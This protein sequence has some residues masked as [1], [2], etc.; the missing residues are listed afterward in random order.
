M[1]VGGAVALRTLA[2]TRA[3][4]SVDMEDAHATILKLDDQRWSNWS[5]FGI[6]DGHAGYRTAAKAADKLHSRI[7]ST[8]NSSVAE[9]IS[10][11]S[12][13]E[14][15]SSQIDFAKF[16]SAIKDAYFKFD[17]EWREENRTNNP[18]TGRFCTSAP[19]CGHVRC[20]FADDR[21]GS[22]AISCLIDNERV[23][24]L[25]VGDSRGILVSTEGRVLLATKDHKPSRASFVRTTK[26]CI[27]H[28]SR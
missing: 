20:S 21:S 25:N 19:A 7:L 5:Y 16:E 14:I 22:T 24:F 11:K 6:F 27:H 18:G 28:S 15:S 4:S 8:L 10:T 13:P 3:N 12:S 17:H 1:A 2:R 26:S 9:P 23:Y